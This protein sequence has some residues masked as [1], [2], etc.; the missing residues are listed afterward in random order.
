[1]VELKVCLQISWRYSHLF[2]GLMLMLIHYHIFLKIYLI[3]VTRNQPIEFSK[4]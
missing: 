1:M 2:Q 4:N 3:F